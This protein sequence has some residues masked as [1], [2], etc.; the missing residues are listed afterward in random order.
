MYNNCGKVHV[1]KFVMGKMETP[2]TSLNAIHHNPVKT[3]TPLRKNRAPFSGYRKKTSS[4]LATQSIGSPNGTRKERFFNFLA[5]TL[6]RPL[7]AN[8]FEIKKIEL[9]IKNLPQALEGLKIVQISDLHFYPFSS[10]KYFN[11]ALKAISDIKPD[12]IAITGDIVN[13]GTDH[14]EKAKNFFVQ[15]KAPLGIV[16]CLGNHDY[17]DGA[18]S[19]NVQS[20]L[21]SSGITPLINHAI[22]LKKNGATL[23][24][25]GLDDFER[26]QPDI[27]NTFIKL[28]SSSLHICLAHNPKEADNLATHSKAPDLILSGHTHGG[29]FKSR[30]LDWIRHRWF[31]PPEKYLQGKFQLNNSVLY[32]NRGLGSAFNA[33]HTEC[34]P[35]RYKAK[36][37]IAVFTF[38]RQ[39]V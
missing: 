34:P 31:K 14:L 5:H 13:K 6:L 3:R 18:K 27:Q 29:Q 19:K 26:G 15:L 38:S 20:I 21:K 35:L 28:E 30:L 9:S 25:S 32:V 36:P 11:K 10:K 23:W 22:P 7:L 39:A 37:E 33:F 8:Q 2:M 16:A 1:N 4:P 17:S 24:V 12:L